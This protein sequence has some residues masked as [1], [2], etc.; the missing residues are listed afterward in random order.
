MGTAGCLKPVLQ[1]EAPF[2]TSPRLSDVAGKGGN[3]PVRRWQKAF[4]GWVFSPHFADI[5][6]ESMGSC[7]EGPKQLY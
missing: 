2:D 3:D 6:A 7:S 5:A 1:A 4:F